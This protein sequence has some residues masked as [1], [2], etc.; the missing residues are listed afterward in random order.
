MRW[1]F[2]QNYL[3]LW[4]IDAIFDAKE[5]GVLLGSFDTNV[6]NLMPFS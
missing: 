5:S 2:Q 6:T 1:D 4:N 3:A